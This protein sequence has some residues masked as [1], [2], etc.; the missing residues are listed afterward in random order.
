MPGWCSAFGACICPRDA[1]INAAAR[2]LLR[3]HKS[4]TVGLRAVAVGRD[5]V[6]VGANVVANS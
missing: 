1:T 3:L 2:E 4:A 5:V 6:V